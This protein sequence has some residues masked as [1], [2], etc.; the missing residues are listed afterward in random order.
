M[1]ITQ[2]NLAHYPIKN[3]IVDMTRWERLSTGNCASN[4]I[5]NIEN[6][7]I[8]IDQ[9]LSMKYNKSSGTLRFKQIAQSMSEDGILQLWTKRKKDIQVS[10]LDCSDKSYSNYESKLKNE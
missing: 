6:N 3:S 5:C 7:T 1:T 4:C 9:S 10:A 2:L 8:C